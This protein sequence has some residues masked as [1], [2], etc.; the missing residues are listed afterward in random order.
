[1]KPAIGITSKHL[2]SVSQAL[3]T[4]LADEFVL[5][6][7]TRG[8]HWNVEGPDFHSMHEYFE[9]LYHELEEIIDE[10]AERMR[11][12]GHYASAT[13]HEYSGLTH[14]AETPPASNK[15]KD[16]IKAMLNDHEAIIIHL[17]ESIQYFDETLKDA[18]TA[19]FIT[20]LMQKHETIA[21][22]LRSH[23]K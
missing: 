11:V 3:N 6:T 13:L 23:L 18:G 12:L 17:R 14:L 7:K 1:M 4:I 5:Y 2:Q 9:S 20:S 22:M 8:A 16:Y 19:D 15:S 21:W 10:V